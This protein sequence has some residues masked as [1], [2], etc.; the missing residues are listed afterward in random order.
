MMHVGINYLRWR[1]KRSGHSR[2]MRTR[3]FTYLERVPLCRTSHTND[4]TIRVTTAVTLHPV[5]AFFIL[6]AALVVPI[7]RFSILPHR[8]AK[9]LAKK[10]R[11]RHRTETFSALLAF[12]DGN[13]P[14]T[15]RFPS[16]RPVTQSF[17]FSLICPWRNGWG[18][19]RDAGDLRRRHANYDV[20]IMWRT[21]TGYF[22]HFSSLGSH[23]FL[24]N[25]AVIRI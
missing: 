19:N 20:T 12:C 11:W 24:G 21:V 17:V 7:I 6:N 22:S 1:G 5:V 10:S 9:H 2:R 3:N 15:G 8:P 23:C 18:N 13:P 25:V 4:F 16:Q 14:V